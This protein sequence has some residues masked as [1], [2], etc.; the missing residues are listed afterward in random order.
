MDAILIYN[1]MAGRLRRRPERLVQAVEKLTQWG[2]NVS[3]RATTGPMAAAKMARKAVL[4]APDVI[5][6][7]GG[8]GLINEVING[9]AG[10]EIPLGILPGGTANV[11]A[12]ELGIR[13]N[14]IRAAAD[15]PGWRAAPIALGYLEARGEAPRYFCCMAGV[16]LDAMVVYRVNARIKAVAGKLAYYVA[17]FAQLGR[18]LPLL[19]VSV[20]GCSKT[21]SFALI[22][23]VKNYGGDLWIARQASLLSDDFEAVLFE[24]A[25]TWPYLS[26]WASIL[27]GRDAPGIRRLRVKE[28]Q[29][30]GKD[31]GVFIQVDGELAGQLPARVS[32]VPGALRLL[33]PPAFLNRRG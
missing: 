15:L 19:E 7:A 18:R 30:T 26:Y 5:L 22:S 13:S 29:L 24:G 32:I 14:L 8:D 9:M 21:C 33:V 2:W 25:S 3:L 12:T 23:R 10:S 4:E 27:L 31:P 6:A 20:N 11:L 17:S 28:L 1:P 16:G